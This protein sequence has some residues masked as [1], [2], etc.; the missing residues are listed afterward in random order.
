MYPIL[1]VYN[2][3]NIVYKI[4]I[5][6]GFFEIAVSDSVLHL[7]K[8]LNNIVLFYLFSLIVNNVARIFNLPRKNI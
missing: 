6:I 7:T 3:G 4:I 1:K 2:K 5:A 8:I